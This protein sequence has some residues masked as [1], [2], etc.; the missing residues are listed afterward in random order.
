MKI[1]AIPCV[2]VLTLLCA[3]PVF[4]APLPAGIDE[5]KELGKINGRAM[6]CRQA[7]ILERIDQE[8][9]A[10]LPQPTD[11]AYDR[12]FKTAIEESFLA[13]Q[14]KDNAP[15][16]TLEQVESQIKA[17]VARLRKALQAR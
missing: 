16:Q 9:K 5:V 7:A 4:A 8:L 1:L 12:A 2:F 13:Q 6:L 14:K 11:I 15:C 17:I 10:A 3:F